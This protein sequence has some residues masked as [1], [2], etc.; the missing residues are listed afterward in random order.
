ME[1][2]GDSNGKNCRKCHVY[3]NFDLYYKNNKM[4]DG[5]HSY[6]KECTKQNAKQYNQSPSG[7]IKLY[8]IQ[9]Q[10]RIRS[11]KQ[12]KNNSIILKEIDRKIYENNL[13]LK[14]LKKREM[15]INKEMQIIKEMQNF[16]R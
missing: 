2:L 4:T 16:N 11:G 9:K 10:Y 5:R 13:K 3:K 6:C 7:S 12:K 1:S 8:A 15:E 14:E